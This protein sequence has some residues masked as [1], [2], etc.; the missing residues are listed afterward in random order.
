MKILESLIS[1]IQLI[2]IMILSYLLAPYILTVE[3]Y[4]EENNQVNALFPIAIVE[5][6]IPN[7]VK[8]DK[9]IKSTEFK[10]NLFL[11]SNDVIYKLEYSDYFKIKRLESDVYEV[12]Y[13]TGMYLIKSRYRVNEDV[14]E[15]K[16]FYLNGGFIVLPVFCILL[17]LT[18]LM[19]WVIKR[20]LRNKR[21]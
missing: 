21:G 1:I 3:Y 2:I 8:W 5:G 20:S 16:Y 6:G 10:S 15:P 11:E 4:D 13:N 19:N 17:L 18:I 12:Y 9:Y 7:I 14:I